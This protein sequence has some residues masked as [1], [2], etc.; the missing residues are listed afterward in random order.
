V[1]VTNDL[2]PSTLADAFGYDP[3]PIV[4]VVT[5]AFG[6]ET[7]G[8]DVTILG[9]FFDAR[10]LEVAVEFDGVPATNVVLVNGSTITC[11]T[12]AGTGLADVTVTNLNGEGLLVDGFRYL[13]EEILC[14]TGNVNAGVGPIADVLFINGS[15]GSI[16]DRIVTVAIGAPIN[17]NVIRAPEKES[18]TSRFVMY[19]YPK[20]VPTPATVTQQVRGSRDI[21]TGCMPTPF[22]GGTPQPVFIFNNIGRNNL[23][24]TPN[25]PSTP[26]PSTLFNLPGGVD[27]A[28]DVTFMGF[29]VDPGSASP[30]GASITNTIV[31][32]V[33]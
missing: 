13:G 31:L 33:Q 23:L 30:D 18:G 27:K 2:G 4:N 5:P 1:V 15:A 6:P 14:R 8:T 26:A 22:S 9:A 20:K 19:G 10:D 17:A 21:G 24:G 11:T 25:K 12:P 29:I 16:P 28:I 7:G 32:R 3:A